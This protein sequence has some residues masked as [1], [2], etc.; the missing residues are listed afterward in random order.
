MNTTA[1]EPC[2]CVV[3]MCPDEAQGEY[4]LCRY[5]AELYA[6]PAPPAPPAPAAP[7]PDADGIAQGLADLADWVKSFPHS[8]PLRVSIEWAR[9]T[10]AAQAR[11]IAEL[12]RSEQHTRGV[13]RVAERD[14]KERLAAAR[15]DADRLR[16][17]LVTIAAMRLDNYAG[18]HSM[19]LDAVSTATSAIDAARSAAKG[20]GNG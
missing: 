17:A 18:P 16:S 5:H 9:A 20:D 1:A 14:Y 19:S 10:I 6:K 8:A 7:A 4:G 2:R 11:E 3:N 13:L 15:A 12:R